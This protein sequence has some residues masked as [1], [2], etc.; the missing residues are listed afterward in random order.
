MTLR[1]LVRVASLAAFMSLRL[2]GQEAKT[3]AATEASQVRAKAEAGDAK[4][5]VRLGEKYKT[6]DGVPRRASEAVR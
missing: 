1:L 4:A 3:D 2:S 6:G 5:Q